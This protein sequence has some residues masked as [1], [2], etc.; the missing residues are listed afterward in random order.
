MKKTLLLLNLIIPFALFSQT[1]EQR[2][3]ILQSYD[4]DRI[5]SLVEKLK[6]D[7]LQKKEIISKFL[8][9][10][11][12]I[13]KDYT[14]DG[15]RFILYT[16]IDNK[17]I[18]VT[19]YNRESAYSTKTNE[20]HP[21]GELGLELEGEGL[22]VGVWE[23]GGYALGSHVEFTNSD[24]TS[25]ITFPDTSNPSS[26][27]VSFHA[28]HVCG[29]VGASG[30]NSTAKGMAPKSTMVSY[31]FPGH[32]T[33]TI[34]EHLSSGMLV[35]NHSYGIVIDSDTPAWYFGCYN[36]GNIVGSSNDGSA[37]WDGI[38]RGAP[39]YT[40]VDAAGNDG[41]FTYTGGLGPGLDK[42]TFSGC[43]KNNLV[44]ANANVNVQFTPFGASITSVSIAPSSNQGPTDDGRIKPD[45]TG[46]GT[47]VYSAANDGDNDYSNATGTSMAAPNVAGSLI[48]LQ[49][50]YNNLNDEFMKSATLKGL[51]CHTA[52][53]EAEM[54]N[55]TSAAYPGPDPV[56]GWG[57]LD[58]QFAAETITNAQSNLSI[59]EENSL[60]NGESYSK[61][62]TVSD[63]QKL[64][65]TICWTDLAGFTQNGALNSTVPALYNDLDIR[66]FDSSGNEYFPWKLDLNNLP[67]ATKGDNLVDNVERVEIE[68]PT[69]GQ[70]TITIS[71][72]G[73]LKTE[74]SG[75]GPGGGLV[76]GP[77][78]Y[79]LIVTGANMTLSDSNNEMSNLTVWPNPAKDFINFQISSVGTGSTIVSLVDIRGRKVYQNNFNSENI[80][81][82]EI[83]TSNFAKG[84]YILNIEQGNKILNKKVIIE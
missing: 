21:G 78:D 71:H 64:M 39:Y 26:D 84:I 6:S 24:G 17:P 12:N 76:N 42:L 63:S 74:G 20:L 3:K 23:V 19:D 11:P 45:L 29:T 1:P 14:K 9:D 44:I 75:G 51:A 32:K 55:L 72:K 27:D 43:S 47:N 15:K 2:D 36:V 59:I 79:S 16:V 62:I 57:L 35:S 7:E 82:S 50:H 53:D 4:M 40:R 41:N 30:I 8:A 67:Y 34:S 69:P 66:I 56:W 33:E 58:A 81:R 49:E 48:L 68:S 28:T 54:D 37:V 65:A 80:I 22:T 60:D 38:L 61:T 10:N 83:K 77:Q 70:Y 73:L 18:Y 31:D 46:R 52:K 25:R 13:K 5:N